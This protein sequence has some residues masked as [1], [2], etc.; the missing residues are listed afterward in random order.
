MK[1]KQKPKEA[2]IE[3]EPDA[4]PRFERFIKEAAKAGPQHRTAKS[5]AQKRPKPNKNEP[6][7]KPEN[8]N[9][10]RPERSRGRRLVT[11]R[12]RTDQHQRGIGRI[13]A[14]LV[15]AKVGKSG[16]CRMG[17]HGAKHPK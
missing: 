5:V 9:V 3:L 15:S 4:W 16:L 1:Q 12:S 8:C 11:K 7:R 14:A 13:Q 6:K 17:Q 2:K 10:F